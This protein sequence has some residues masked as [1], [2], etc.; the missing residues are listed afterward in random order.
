[1]IT[2]TQKGDFRNLVNFLQKAKKIVK[3]S[4]L[5][6]YGEMGV[7]ALMEATPVR[8]GRTASSWYYKASIRNNV[9]I[10]EFHN[11]NI[12]NGENIALILDLG[13]GS[14]QGCWIEGR[15]YIAPALEPVFEQILEDAWNELNK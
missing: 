11:S 14:K 1:M 15:D 2:I 5:D 8:T 4:D 7:K 12:Q 9:A 3:L 13:H 6:K 10:L